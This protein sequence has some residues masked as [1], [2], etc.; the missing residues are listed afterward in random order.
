MSDLSEDIDAER[1]RRSARTGRKTRKDRQASKRG[2]SKPGGITLLCGCRW[3]YSGGAWRHVTP[4]KVDELHL[5]PATDL[6]MK[7]LAWSAS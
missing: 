4:C 7:F 3:I 2:S 5:T 6:E 1:Q